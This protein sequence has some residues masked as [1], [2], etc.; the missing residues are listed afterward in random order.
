[1]NYALLVV[2][3]LVCVGLF[4]LAKSPKYGFLRH[5]AL[6]PLVIL[7]VLM[8]ILTLN[9][10]FLSQFL[11]TEITGVEEYFTYSAVIQANLL[12][13]G[14]S[15]VLLAAIAFAQ[16]VG[17]GPRKRR[18][19]AP[20]EP[21]RNRLLPSTI[22][23][24]LVSA[25]LSG[26][27]VVAMAV[28]SK[29]GMNL[30]ELIS[31][32]QLFFTDYTW[33]YVVLSTLTPTLAIYFASRSGVTPLSIVLLA[34]AA[35]FSLFTGSRNQILLLGLMFAISLAYDGR[36]FDVKL[37]IPAIPCIA[38]FALVSRYVFRER[39]RFPSLSEFVE[40]KGGPLRVYFDTVEISGAQALTIICDDD[41]L[42]QYP[43]EGFFG[44]LAYPVP[45]KL[46]PG[47]P[48]SASAYFSEIVAPRK[49]DN[50]K[51]EILTTGFGDYQ[52]Q[53]GSAFGMMML[54][55]TACVW[56]LLVIHVIRRP[57]HVAVL[58][59]PYLIYWMYIFIRGDVFALGQSFWAL[60]LMLVIRSCAR[61][62]DPKP[63]KNTL[64]EPGLERVS[65]I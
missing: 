10:F 61:I 44:A 52:M 1:M 65:A 64:D 43:F 6:N 12:M 42:K 31:Q 47:K 40:A 16:S 39:G 15:V 60:A 55:L 17:F 4:A 3:L 50:G 19:P 25:A 23:T 51:S 14:Y 24:I 32:R 26:C 57:R 8:A 46:F 37:L 30:G 38:V 63:V 29:S 27:G 22:I 20:V 21:V 33:I 54:F 53:F 35:V 58:W 13:T 11:G 28:L 56:V 49:W 41:S 5:S 59:L 18:P 45:R 7:A 62:F 9:F 36:K 2:N 34:G 48:V